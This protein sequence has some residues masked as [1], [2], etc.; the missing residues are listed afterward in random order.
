MWSSSGDLEGRATSTAG[1]VAK[2][3]EGVVQR[4]GAARQPRGLRGMLALSDFEGAARRYLP[5]AVHGFI[6][7]A[8]ETDSALRDNASA[9]ADYAFVPRM[10]ADVSGRSQATTLFGRRYAAPF[11][12]APMGASALAA[13]RG[14]LVLARAAAGADLP[15]VLSGSS[16]IRLE[17]VREAGSHWYQAYQPGEPDRIEALVDRVAA[18]GF[19]TFVLTVDIPVPANRE[20]NVRTGYSMPL[21]ITPRL[22]FDAVTHPGW[23]LGTWFRTLRRHGMPHFENMDAT[24][25]PPILS[26][27]L[28]R[29]I[30]RRDQL[31]W[32]HVAL[33]RRRWKGNFV[34]K[35]ILAKEDARLAREH[36]V[37][38]IIVS[39]HGGR[40]LDYAVAPLRV[41][42]EI[43]AEAGGAPHAGGMTIMLDGGIRRG[44]DVLKAL[45]L[46]AHFVF[47]G[48]PFLYAVAVFG[49]AGVRHAIGL[50][51]EEIDRDLALLGL[52]DPAGLGP[53]HLARIK[54]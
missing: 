2:P 33:I 41:L 43:A 29:N 36:G 34:V 14:D 18:G 1:I 4:P 22:A 15:M 6:A 10:L 8:A 39:N 40:Q 47:V 54:G 32:E 21:K 42:P 35:G 31:T 17:E 49:E 16:L 52:R 46:G 37:D 53:Q 45:A 28:V 44:T 11:G 12:I 5:R 20:N 24:R 19:E 13:Y 9:F 30:G 7:G 38:G 3:A 25:G 51:S 27:D 50:L 48:R 26:K 23:L